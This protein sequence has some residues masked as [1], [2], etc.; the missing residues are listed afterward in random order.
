MQ[1]ELCV[2]P[3]GVRGVMAKEMSAGAANMTEAITTAPTLEA[4]ARDV[5]QCLAFLAEQG[6]TF[7]QT[8]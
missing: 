2:T 6:Q 8:H 4:Y 5:R 7:A 3:T 1:E